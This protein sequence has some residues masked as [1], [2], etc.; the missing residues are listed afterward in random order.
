MNIRSCAHC[1]TKDNGM[2]METEK[3]E[4]PVIDIKRYK[5]GFKLQSVNEQENN[6]LV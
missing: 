2:D 5:F 1:Q 4:L 6:F 3:G